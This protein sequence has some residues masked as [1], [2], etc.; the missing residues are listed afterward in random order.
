MNPK[1]E[2]KFVP[3]D[4]KW[5]GLP[6]ENYLDLVQQHGKQGWRLVQVLSSETAVS[7]GF[8]SNVLIFERAER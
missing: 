6:K 4:V 5:T 7:L 2:Y 8:T 1:F 3:I